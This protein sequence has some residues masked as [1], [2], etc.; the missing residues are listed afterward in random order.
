M[1]ITITSKPALKLLPTEGARVYY[2][3]KIKGEIE[4]SKKLRAPLNLALVLD[5]SGS[6]AGEKLRLA[7]EAAAFVVSHLAENDRVSLLTFDDNVTVVAPSVLA[8]MQ[9]REDIKKKT[10]TIRS[11]G[12]TNL[13]EGWFEGCKQVAQFQKEANYIDCVCLMTDGETNAGIV[14]QEELARHASELN[15]RGISTSTF[16]LGEQFNE[17][18]LE[19]LAE[20]GQGNYHFIENQAHIRKYFE[21]ELK[22]R[23]SIVGRRLA[24]EINFGEIAVEVDCLNDYEVSRD[25]H[26]PLIQIGDLSTGEGKVVVVEVKAPP[27]KPG[28][29]LSP[30]AILMYTDPLTGAGSEIRLQEALTMVYT[31]EKEAL[32]EKIDPEYEEL[33]SRLLADRVKRKMLEENRRGDYKAV[34]GTFQNFQASL[35]PMAYGINPASKMPDLEN[36]TLQAESTAFSQTEQKRRKSEIYRNKKGL[37][38]YK[39][40]DNESE[41]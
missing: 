18:L 28:Q 24:L 31:S 30:E 14:D 37:Q 22:E 17:E 9:N 10:Q 8:S 34:R 4:D 2:I 16:G 20:K 33:I 3:F 29:M 11:G 6:M 39:D 32:K 5:R 7:R 19:V 25:P 41:S 1:G 12:S 15:K 35:S 27:G 38:D 23:L 21:G 40:L 36:F 13:S 26:R